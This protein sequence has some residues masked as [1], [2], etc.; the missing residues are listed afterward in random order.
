MNNQAKHWSNVAEGYESEFI[1][2]YR[3]GVR[4]P[5][6]AALDK[7]KGP[8]FRTVADL[9]CG[10]GVLLPE[11]ARRFE[12]V[13]A[14]DFAEGMLDRARK[15]GKNL[16]NVT[17]HC[18][19]FTD[20]ATALDRVDV[21]VAVNSLVLPDI[22]DLEKSL[23]AIHSVLRPGGVFLGIVPGMDAVHYFTMLLL[24][25]ARKTGMPQAAARK[26]A[27][28][29]AEHEF[30]DFAFSEFRFRGLVQHFWHPFEVEYRLRRAG[31]TRIRLA[32]VSLTWE[33]FM[34]GAGLEHYEPPWDWFFEARRR[35][36]R[37]N[38]R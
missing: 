23:G 22:D 3:P 33:Q 18:S 10:I 8:G 5:L 27:A 15:A 4:N 1:D 20:I 32:K 35:A 11:L 6:L 30:Y 19:S 13:H 9:G 38:D 36:R 29:N 28:K 31:F 26:N 25:R 12:H 16:T 21:A 34:S 2:P 24:D 14:I 37:Q 7:L 17:Y